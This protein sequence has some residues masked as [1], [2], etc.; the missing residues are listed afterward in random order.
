MIKNE[1]RDILTAACVLEAALLAAFLAINRTEMGAAFAGPIYGI[2]SLLVFYASYVCMARRINRTMRTVNDTV[3][4]LLEET[5]AVSFCTNEDTLLGKFQTQILKVHDILKSYE[6]REKELRVGLSEL[7]GDL[8]HQMNTPITNIRMYSEFLEQDSLEEAERERFL[9]NILL[10][11]DKLSWLGE[12]FS[13]AS[14]LETGVMQLQQVVQPVFP[15]LLR[16]IDQI[17]LKAESK[18]MSVR[19]R[20]KQDIRAYCDSRWTEEA[21]FN[22]LDNGVKYGER[23]TSVEV[24]VEQY[25]LYIRISV[26]SRGSLLQAS[27]YNKIFQRFYR[28]REAAGKPGVGLGLYL[29]RQITSRQG[30]YVKVK[31]DKNT[32]N[33]FSVYLLRGKS[34]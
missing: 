30:G 33:T 23:G 9:R 22:L 16:A 13:K 12:G 26:S 31:S 10:Q 7:I 24:S 5:P 18:G 8:V 20:G 3:Q 14:R 32:G 25:D 27:E 34:K 17:S 19:L 2:L 6:E 21:F 4:S 11:V 28:G 15:V 1:V 29:V